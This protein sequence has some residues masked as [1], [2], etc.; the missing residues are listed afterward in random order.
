M[1]AS[2]CEP[3]SRGYYPNFICGRRS[4]NLGRDIG[5]RIAH[6]HQRRIGVIPQLRQAQIN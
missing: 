2:R 1:G 5:Y 6:P 4:I 3:T